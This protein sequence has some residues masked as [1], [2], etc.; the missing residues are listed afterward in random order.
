MDLVFKEVTYPQ[1]SL[2]WKLHPQSCCSL[3]SVHAKTIKTDALPAIVQ[4]KD[5]LAVITAS[6]TAL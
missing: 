5:N 6:V 3:S 1:F 4:I 2:T